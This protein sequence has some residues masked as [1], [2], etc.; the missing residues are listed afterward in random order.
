MRQP[1]LALAA[2][3]LLVLAAAGPLAAADEGLADSVNLRIKAGAGTPEVPAAPQC[4]GGLQN[5]DGTVENGYSFNAGNGIFDG[6]HFAERY[7]P[8]TGPFRFSQVCVCLTGLGLT[9]SAPV[10]VVFFADAGGQ[11]GTEIARVAANATGIP[12]YPATAFFDVPV[13]VDTNGPVWVAASWNVDTHPQVFVCADENGA[14]GAVPGMATT[15]GGANWEPLTSYLN[16]DLAKAVFIRAEAAPA[17]SALEVPT[18]GIAGLAFLALA[19]GLLAFFLLR[20]R[21]A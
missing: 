2:L 5:D 13:Q 19:L 15:D 7:D 4:A 10:E 8:G 6:A 11:P 21:P 20:R 17:P 12:T 18:L 1:A 16:W 14:G 3:S 9:T